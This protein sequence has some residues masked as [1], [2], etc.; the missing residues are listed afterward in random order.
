MPTS[1]VGLFCTGLKIESQN[2]KIWNF[3]INTEIALVD[4]FYRNLRQ[5]EALGLF[6]RKNYDFEIFDYFTMIYRYMNFDQIRI[7]ENIEKYLI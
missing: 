6:L 4:G 3:Q 7:C 5:V 2:R 1:Q